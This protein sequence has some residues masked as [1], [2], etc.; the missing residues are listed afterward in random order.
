MQAGQATTALKAPVPVVEAAALADRLTVV[1]RGETLQ[2][3]RLPMCWR[4]RP[5]HASNPFSVC[6]SLGS[7]ANPSHPELSL[8]CPKLVPEVP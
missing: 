4:L 6:L 8:I 2:S 3:G 5:V 1:D 7:S